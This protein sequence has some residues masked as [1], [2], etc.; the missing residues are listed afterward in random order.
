MILGYGLVFFDC[1]RDSV[2]KQIIDHAAKMGSTV[3][4]SKRIRKGK[5]RFRDDW[6]VKFAITVRYARYVT[7]SQHPVNL[8]PFVMKK[9][10][11]RSGYGRKTR[12]RTINFILSITVLE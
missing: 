2:Q 1:E 4:S 3:L 7:S 9:K 6:K 5:R 8:L 10:Q 11:N 12:R